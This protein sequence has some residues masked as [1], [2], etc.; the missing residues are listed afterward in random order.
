MAGV[1]IELRPGEVVAL[2]GANGSGKTTLAKVLAQ[3]YEPDQGIV[4]WNGI[5]AATLDHGEFRDQIAVIFQ[6]FEQ[7]MF[8]AAENIGSAAP[9][10]STTAPAK[11]PTV[12]VSES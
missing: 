8:S 1:T 11:Q 4:L 12:S 6:D 10:T 9:N 7:Y 5:D 2:V 3:L